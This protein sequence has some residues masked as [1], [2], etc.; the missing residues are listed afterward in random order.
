MISHPQTRS[1]V[2]INDIEWQRLRALSGL[3]DDA[4]SEVQEV[5]LFLSQKPSLKNPR[6]SWLQRDRSI[7]TT[8]ERDLKR[9]VV[10]ISALIESGAYGYLKTPLEV[11]KNNH[12]SAVRMS[13]HEMDDLRNKLSKLIDQLANAKRGMP[14][15]KAGRHQG[16]FSVAVRWLDEIALKS[17]GAGL[18]PRRRKGSQVDH[19]AFVAAVC[20]AGDLPVEDSTVMQEI[21]ERRAAINNIG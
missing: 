9:A 21:K 13:R 7:I 6:V 5:I 4:R 2:N 10:N 1:L 19:T 11:G 8:A 20:R 16:H 18:S 14:R 15:A 17:T 3:P 12:A